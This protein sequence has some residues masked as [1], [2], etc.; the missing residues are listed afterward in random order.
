MLARPLLRWR[1]GP[2]LATLALLAFIAAALIGAVGLM[3]QTIMAERHQ[4]EQAARTNAVLMALR[5]VSRTAVNGETGQR[6]YLITLDRRYLAPYLVARRQYRAN[7]ARLHRLMGPD[8]TPHQRALLGEIEALNAGKFAELDESVALIGAGELLEARRRMLTDKGQDMMERLRVAVAALETVELASFQVARDRAVASEARIVPLLVVLAGVIVTAL[9]LG[10]VQVIR[11]ADAEARAENAE[12]LRLARDQADLLASEL[13][14]R[15]KNLFAVILAIVR[16][17]GRD[18][19]AAAPTVER[20]ADRIH[21]LLTAH[22]VTQGTSARRSAQLGDLVAN[23]LRPYRSDEHR[24]EIAG[25]EVAL[26]ERA[27]VPFGLVL[28]ELTTNAVK[29]GAW[30]Q[31][32]G[33]L[34]VRWQVGDDRLRFDW[35][36]WPVEPAPGAPGGR[37]FGSTL[38]DSAARQLRGTIERTFTSAGIVVRIAIPLTA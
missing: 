16:M 3:A 20:I 1:R 13:N 27:I 30:A 17:S 32:G 34:V 4:R 35:T 9:G 18:Q 23:A 2:G 31:P 12:A 8:P 24:C 22:E 33:L 28:H 10:L 11:A 6:G 38:I 5:D 25:P 15:V 36:E 26:P 7:I 19:P 14:H 29:Y 21:A 37:G